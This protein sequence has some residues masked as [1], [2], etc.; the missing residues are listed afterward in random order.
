MSEKIE[1]EVKEEK[2]ELTDSE[3]EEICDDY[4]IAKKLVQLKQSADSRKLEFSLKFKTVK[5]LLN[6][7]TCFYTGKPFTKKGPHARSI[8]RVDSTRGYVD[9]NVVACTTEINA[10]KANLTISEIALIARK[11]EARGKKK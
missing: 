11:I 6:A 7:K 1:E 10:K 4:Y 5:K 9:D 3:T 8:D 2:I